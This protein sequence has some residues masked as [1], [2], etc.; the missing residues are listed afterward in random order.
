MILEF[1]KLTPEAIDPT[2]A[3]DSDAGLDLYASKKVP[4]T[5]EVGRLKYYQYHTGIAVNI[6]VGYVGLIFP[7]SSIRS[8]D[9]TLANCV[10][11]IDAGYT[12]EITFCFRETDP[13]IICETYK[14][15]DKIGQ[16]VIVPIVV[17]ELKEVTDFPTTDR[18]DNGYGSSGA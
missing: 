12:G 18:G 16:L 15:G 8:Y 11:V 17:P 3:H 1:K 2:R 5:N 14:I 9:L 6:P 7:R 4:V 13:V 10:G